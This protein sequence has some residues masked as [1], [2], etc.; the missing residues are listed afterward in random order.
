[1][2]DD[3][4]VPP[5]GPAISRIVPRRTS[6]GLVQAGLGEFCFFI[7]DR[8]FACEHI[9]GRCQVKSSA[10]TWPGR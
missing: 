4:L 3:C 5:G 2:A 7:E 9:M 8:P 6:S 1:M 10:I